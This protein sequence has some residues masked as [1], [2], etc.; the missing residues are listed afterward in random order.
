MLLKSFLQPKLSIPSTFIGF[1]L[2]SV[3]ACEGIKSARGKIMK[4]I[5]AKIS[6]NHFFISSH[7]VRRTEDQ[8]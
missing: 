7:V 2:H 6:D 5:L 3:C 8:T 1:M 4:I